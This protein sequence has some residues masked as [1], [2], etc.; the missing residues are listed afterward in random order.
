MHVHEYSTSPRRLR[1]A[2]I[3]DT[4][5]QRIGFL[6]VRAMTEHAIAAVAG[7]D[8]TEALILY[9]CRR[10][11]LGLMKIQVFFLASFFVY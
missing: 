1:E 8:E 3:L 11:V 2:A 7:L 5:M 6:E 4:W 9:F 10:P